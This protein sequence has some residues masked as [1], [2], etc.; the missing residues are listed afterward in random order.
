MNETIRSALALV[1]SSE[2]ARR[3]GA[4]RAPERIDAVLAVIA[5][6][7]KQRPDLRLG[8]LVHYAA[9]QHGFPDSYGVE[10]A[11][12][13][14]A[15]D[16]RYAE[17]LAPGT[18]ASL[19]IEPSAPAVPAAPAPAPSE[20]ESTL[21]DFVAPVL[22]YPGVPDAPVAVADGD[23]ANEVNT[24]LSAVYPAARVASVTGTHPMVAVGAIGDEYLFR[25]EFERN[26][27][28]LRL[29]LSTAETIEVLRVA[30]EDVTRRPDAGLL[31]AGKLC[32][33]L[34]S[35]I[36]DARRAI[37]SGTLSPAG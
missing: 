9:R 21:P 6:H 36:R 18:T 7:W 10:D 33:V 13:L 31:S 15:L 14:T 30:M 34:N 4:G 16:R 19:A 25:L 12:L 27:A 1:R 32:G 35:L 11:E 8:E 23:L 24:L 37:E 5:D 22:D 28:I 26:T 17:L 29:M 3:D 20:P 2:L